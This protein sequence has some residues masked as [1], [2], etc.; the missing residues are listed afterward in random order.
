VE[1]GEMV[2]LSHLSVHKGVNLMEMDPKE[3]I[4]GMALKYLE[5]SV[6]HVIQT[7]M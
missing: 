4:S 5:L 7:E 3:Y 1:D 6:N 2:P